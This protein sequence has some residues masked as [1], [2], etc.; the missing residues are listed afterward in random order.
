MTCAALGNAVSAVTKWRVCPYNVSIFCDHKFIHQY[1]FED[2]GCG[3]LTLP[4]VDMLPRNGTS[5]L[6]AVNSH[7]A[8]NM[9]VDCADC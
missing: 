2:T 8:K 4:T 9:N 7:V 3:T 6:P 5:T 1:D